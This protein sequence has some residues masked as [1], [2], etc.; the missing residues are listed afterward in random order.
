MIEYLS[1]GS[2]GDLLLQVLRKELN[3]EVELA[4]LATDAIGILVAPAQELNEVRVLKG[5]SGL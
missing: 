3:I 4:V 2:S 5:L 1:G